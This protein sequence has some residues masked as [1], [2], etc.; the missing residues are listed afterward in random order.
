[1]KTIG[2]QACKWPLTR[3]IGFESSNMTKSSL[4]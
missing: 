1:M 2:R 4:I 3:N